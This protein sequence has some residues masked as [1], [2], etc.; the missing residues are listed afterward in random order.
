M[1][2]KT[3]EFNLSDILEKKLEA[4]EIGCKTSLRSAEGVRG[5][6]FDRVASLLLNPVINTKTRSG[7][8]FRFDISECGISFDTPSWQL[9][10]QADMVV[11]K[12]YRETKWDRDHPHVNVTAEMRETMLYWM[13]IY[14]KQL[15]T[16]RDGKSK[17]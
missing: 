13:R 5:M 3:L 15:Q 7:R 11:E 9:E 4:G 1:E 14:V 17:D 2:K 10:Q 6:Q 8:T 12:K 16:H